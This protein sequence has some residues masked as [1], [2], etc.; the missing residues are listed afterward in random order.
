MSKPRRRL[1]TESELIAEE[2]LRL[3][4]RRWGRAAVSQFEALVG[5]EQTVAAK[6]HGAGAVDADSFHRMDAGA[7]TELYAAIMK[8]TPEG[9]IFARRFFD[10]G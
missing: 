6:T 7:V 4:A 1:A 9:K 8:P 5:C 3:Y 2:I 10:P